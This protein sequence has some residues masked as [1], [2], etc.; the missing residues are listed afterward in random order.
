MWQEIM[1]GTNYIY[2][3]EKN[4]KKLGIIKYH[5]TLQPEMDGKL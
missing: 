5:F 2:S 4:F 1:H 3:V